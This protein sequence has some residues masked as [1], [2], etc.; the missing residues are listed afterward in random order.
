MGRDTP[1]SLA[2]GI[3][4]ETTKRMSEVI[5]EQLGTRF[6]NRI[7]VLSGPN[8]AKEI[9]Q[10]L[11]TA[12]V[13]ASTNTEVASAIQQAISSENFRAYTNADI[14]G[15]ELGGALKNAKVALAV[16]MSDGLGY[17]DEHTG[18]CLVE[19]G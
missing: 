9:V 12:T 4:I 15:V 3:E 14:I 17:V 5:T 16:G 18:L 1:P 2:K 11:P 10:G 6:R 8:F 13:V 7:A 19:Q